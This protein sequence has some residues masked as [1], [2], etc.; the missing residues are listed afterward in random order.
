MWID[1]TN[2]HT[3][4][5]FLRNCLLLLVDPL[6]F[7]MLSP[8]ESFKSSWLLFCCLLELTSN[9]SF[10]CSVDSSTPCSSIGSATWSWLL[11]SFSDFN[12]V[13]CCMLELDKLSFVTYELELFLL[14]ATASPFCCDLLLCSSAC[15]SS[16]L[17][18]MSITLFLPNLRPPESTEY[19][20]SLNA[21]SCP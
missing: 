5:Y 21:E 18:N 8:N 13:I 15:S 17:D 9:D 14:S 12:G 16:S 4:S 20:D 19:F 6:L 3:W 10:R 2:H 7:F 11:A 1:L